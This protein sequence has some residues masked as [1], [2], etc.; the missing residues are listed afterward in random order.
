MYVGVD[1][2]VLWFSKNF[3]YERPYSANDV[4]SGG[5][6]QRY[7]YHRLAAKDICKDRINGTR[8]VIRFSFTKIN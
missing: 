1:A 3:C 6:C 7:Q 5:H 2:S 8:K 4:K